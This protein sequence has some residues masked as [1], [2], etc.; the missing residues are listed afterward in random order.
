MLDHNYRCPL[1]LTVPEALNPGDLDKMFERIVGD[2]FY[3][4]FEPNILS[5]P[6]P[7]ADQKA[8]D[9][10]NGPWIVELLKLLTDDECDT[11][12]DLGAEE[13]YKASSDIGKKNFDG[14]YT[15]SVNSGRTST[16]AWCVN[17]CRVHETTN[18]VHNKIENVTGIPQMN[19][20]Y[21]QLLR[22]EPGQFYQTHHDYIP[23]HVDRQMGVRTLTVFLYLNDVEEGGGTNFPHLN[24]VVKPK[25]GKAVIWP[26]VL[27]RDPN[28]RDGR[29]EHGALPVIKGIKYGANAWTHQRDFKTVLAAGCE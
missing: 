13:G 17:T 27:D 6:N 9:I 1:D 5:M 8:K 21:L 12:I 2:E 14:S 4:Q 25:K 3:Q 18:R 22:Y 23:H 11:M 28:A 15:N 29:T 24:L 16:N 10:I 19:S 26:S 20:E 7:S